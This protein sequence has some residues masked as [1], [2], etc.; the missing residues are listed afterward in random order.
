MIL[1]TP[2]Y[3]S[4]PTCIKPKFHYLT[5][6]QSPGHVRDKVADLSQTATL[7]RTQIMKVRNTNHA[8]DFHDLRPRQ[9]R[10]FVGNLSRTL[11]QTFPVHCNGLNSIRTT[12][13]GL[14]RT[15][16]RLSRKHLDISRWFVS[17]T[18]MICVHVFPSREVSVKVDIMEFGL[19]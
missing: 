5:L 4:F 2:P 12:Q 18:F 19:Y 16:H 8:A 17:S 7:S 15:C 1:N 13:M 14:S 11:S 9:V 6:R 3:W 10:N